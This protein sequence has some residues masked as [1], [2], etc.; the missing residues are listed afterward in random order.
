VSS[1]MSGLSKR[2]C[3]AVLSEV[4]VAVRSTPMSSI[5]I[6]GLGA[7]D[8]WTFGPVAGCEEDGSTLLILCIEVDY[9][10]TGKDRTSNRISACSKM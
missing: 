5:W 3:N 4:S 9:A 7:I 10:G 2:W 1:S 6:T 8:E